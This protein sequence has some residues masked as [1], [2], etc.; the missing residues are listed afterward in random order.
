MTRSKREIN[1]RLT[2]SI[3]SLDAEAAK[4]FAEEA[5]RE[6]LEPFDAVRALAKGMRIVGEKWNRMEI[7]MPEVLVAADAFYSGMTPLENVL[8]SQKENKGYTATMIIG[9]I[10]GDVHTVGKD[11]AKAVFAAELGLKVIDLGVEVPSHQ[12]VEA[13]KQHTAQI[14]GIGTYMSETFYNAPKVIDSLREAGLR[15]NLIVVCGGPAVNNEKSLEF[16]AD[17]AWDDAWVA[18]ENIKQLIKEKLGV[19]VDE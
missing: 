9:T 8:E 3:V 1:Q 14:V 11:V 7:F 5:I 2:D 15:D 12:F 17:G 6:G 13:V 16:G 18:V 19:K 4:K 10:F